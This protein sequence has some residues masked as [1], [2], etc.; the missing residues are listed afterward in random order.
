[1]SD[2]HGWD[3]VP[4]NE[5]M[6]SANKFV[7]RDYGSVRSF[8]AAHEDAGDIWDRGYKVRFTS[9]FVW[10]P[11]KWA[12]IGWSG[13]GG[14]TTRDK[15]L[16]E[17]KDPFIMVC[18]VVTKNN[19]RAKKETLGKVVGF[20]LVS[21]KKGH[22]NEFSHPECHESCPKQWTHALRALRAF[23]FLPESRIDAN[24]FYP[25]LGGNAMEITSQSV[26]LDKK[27]IARIREIPWREDDI[28]RPVPALRNNVM[29]RLSSPSRGMVRAGPASNEGYIV[30]GGTQ[31]L[32]RELYILRL[33]GDADAYLGQAANGQEIIKVGL[34]VS[35]ERRK[36]DF[37]K[38]LP[39]GAFHWEAIRT[40]RSCGLPPCS[41]HSIAVKGEDAMKN[42][43]E[44]KA[45]WLGGE[46]YLAKKQDIDE[47]WRLGCQAAREARD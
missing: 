11:D 46:F 14:K 21:H 38:A 12:A 1:M 16:K 10:E 6:R 37:Q 25:D 26:P 27:L 13:A 43:L 36:S 18:Y 3:N 35:P 20:Y 47:A 39:K 44:K 2:A 23:S 33:E 24:K 5:L 4:G 31:S 29:A 42:Y 28:Y 30:S 7:V 15:L 19:K 34:S 32:P 9:V 41:S 40:M 8:W 22:R 45:E 17:M